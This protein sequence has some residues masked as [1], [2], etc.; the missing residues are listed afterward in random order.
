MCGVAQAKAAANAATAAKYPPG[1]SCLQFIARS[2]GCRCSGVLEPLA[3]SFDL[4][5]RNLDSERNDP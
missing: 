3:L 2:K 4:P 5:R 1:K